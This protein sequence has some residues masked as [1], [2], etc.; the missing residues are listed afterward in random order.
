[1]KSQIPNTK[2]KRRRK[3][4]TEEDYENK[5]KHNPQ[6]KRSNCWKNHTQHKLLSEID[7]KIF[8][9]RTRTQI[10]EQA[11]I[12]HCDTALTFHARFFAYRYEPRKF[13]ASLFGRSKNWIC[14]VIDETY[15]KID[16]YWSKPYL[17]NASQPLSKQYWNRERAHSF[18]CCPKF[19][20][21]IR[22]IKPESDGVQ[23]DGN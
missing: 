3:N 8:T 20:Y 2:Y 19:A 17:L 15:E 21:L 13:H 5:R 10:I 4:P 22:G 6:T 14:K 23:S 9:G 16:K 18:I 12:C 11:K 1:M 7:C